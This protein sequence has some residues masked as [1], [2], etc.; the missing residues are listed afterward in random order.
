M[1]R[2]KAQTFQHTVYSYYAHSGRKLPWRR[3]RGPYPIWISEVMLQQTQVERV[4]PKYREFLKAFPSVHALATASFADV[5][6]V[7]QGLGYNRRAR[8]LL[9]AAREVVANHSGKLPCDERALR[10]LPGIGPYTA[11]AIMVF[12]H[13]KPMTLIETN[14]RSVFLHEF[15]PEAEGVHDND[16]LPLIEAML[17]RDNPREWY[18]ALMD[19]G[20]HLKKEHL[21][22]SRR[23]KHHTK[24]STFDGSNRQLRGK[25]MAELLH[26]QRTVGDIVASAGVTRAVI[27]PALNELKKEGLVQQSGTA[28][29]LSQ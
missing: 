8:N 4:L 29:W 6:N 27:S 24:Q 2:T 11:A 9:L 22:P 25:I 5:L 23:S 7:W 20:A 3:T 12:A 28:V 17:D 26:G 18:W 10:E 21:N 13:N 1:P 15:F 16:I 14:I 19:Y